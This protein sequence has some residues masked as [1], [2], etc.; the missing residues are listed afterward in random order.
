MEDIGFARAPSASYPTN[1]PGVAW[2]D[3]REWLELVERAGE[4]K[5][6]KAAVDPKEELSA[7]TYM[8]TRAEGAPA[9]LFENLAGAGSD[10]RVLANMLGASR[11]R[12]AL[13]VGI[14]PTLSIAEMITATRSIMRA[15]LAPV[16]VDKRVAPVN[17][18][19]LR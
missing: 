14:D 16:E 15:R 8:A 5:R 10:A 19:I 2:H 17:E 9:L 3:L 11:E 6:V 18:V 12:Y 13:A 4:L 7:I 1:R